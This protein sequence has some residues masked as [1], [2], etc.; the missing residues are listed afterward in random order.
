MTWHFSDLGLSVLDLGIYAD[1]LKRLRG[2]AEE[3][4]EHWVQHEER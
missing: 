4:I 3:R 2:A 1:E